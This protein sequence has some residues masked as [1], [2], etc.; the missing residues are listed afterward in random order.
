MGNQISV[1]VRDKGFSAIFEVFT[2]M[3]LTIQDL[4]ALNIHF[5][6]PNTTTLV[7]LGLCCPGQPHYSQRNSNGTAWMVATWS[8][9]ATERLSTATELLVIGGRLCRLSARDRDN[10][11][12]PCLICISGLWRSAIW[13]T[14]R[15]CRCSI[16][17]I[18]TGHVRNMHLWHL[19]AKFTELMARTSRVTPTGV[20]KCGSH[21]YTFRALSNQIP[22]VSLSEAQI[23][24]NGSSK[25]RSLQFHF[26]TFWNSLRT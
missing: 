11:N 19:T 15:F 9:V 5:T 2:E 4:Q 17:P 21:T 23:M 13:W 10:A 18:A 16:Y 25:H 6:P 1:P 24:S 7:P 26:W 20:S 22:S 3:L 12:P 14:L 8:V